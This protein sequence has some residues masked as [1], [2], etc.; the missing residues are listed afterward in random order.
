M[1]GKCMCFAISLLFSLVLIVPAMGEEFDRF[2][3]TLNSH[4]NFLLYENRLFA[5]VTGAS[6][7]NSSDTSSSEKNDEMDEDAQIAEA[8]LNPL[9]YLWLAFIQNDTTWYDGDLM[10]QLNEDS[11]VQNTTLIM[12]VLSM[13]LTEEW[14]A[15]IRPVIP[16]NSFNTVGE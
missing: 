16:I 13:Q 8:M 3:L 10:D 9:S 14:K 1:Y 12:P 4:S 6:T 15:I 5:D 2:N 7:H 11:K